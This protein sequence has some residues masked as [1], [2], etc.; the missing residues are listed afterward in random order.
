MFGRVCIGSLM[1][2]PQ[3]R[4][5]TTTLGPGTGTAAATTGT[6]AA[7]TGT[8]EAEGEAAATGAETGGAEPGAEPQGSLKSMGRDTTPGGSQATA[9][10]GSAV[11]ATI[12]AWHGKEVGC[13]ILVYWSTNVSVI[14]GGAVRQMVHGEGGPVPGRQQEG[15]QG[16]LC[17]GRWP[18]GT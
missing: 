18:I 15:R 14:R 13:S 16:V 10:S 1:R 3:R 4:S 17:L 7:T 5:R 9:G 6:V 11:S 2:K 12:R 8:A